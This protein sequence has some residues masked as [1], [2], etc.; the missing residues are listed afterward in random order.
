MKTAG[1]CGKNM[2]YADRASATGQSIGIKSYRSGIVD[3]DRT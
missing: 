1:N 2:N 3:V